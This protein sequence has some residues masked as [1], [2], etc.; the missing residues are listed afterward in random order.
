M[1]QN[2]CMLFFIMTGRKLSTECSKSM[3][4]QSDQLFRK[5]ESTYVLRTEFFIEVQTKKE[6]TS[7][8]RSKIID[9]CLFISGWVESLRCVGNLSWSVIDMDTT[10]NKW[11]KSVYRFQ[12]CM[13]YPDFEK[14]LKRN[15]YFIHGVSWCL[16]HQWLQN[17]GMESALEFRSW[18]CSFLVSLTD[19]LKPQK[20]RNAAFRVTK[21]MYSIPIT[22]NKSMN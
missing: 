5:S 17:G 19:S 2:I 13:V 22:L 21:K 7:Q 20:L 18:A 12:D 15:W 11:K 16:V 1:E 9:S 8:W 4:D 6:C 3:F 14:S 10:R